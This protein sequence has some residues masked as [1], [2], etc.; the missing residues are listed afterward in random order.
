MRM[1][2]LKIALTGLASVALGSAAVASDVFNAGAD[3]LYAGA[4]VLNGH[5]CDQHYYGRHYNDPY[6]VRYYNDPYYDDRN[7]PTAAVKAGP[8]IKP[9]KVQIICRTQRLPWRHGS[10]SVHVCYGSA[11]V[12]SSGW[13]PKPQKPPM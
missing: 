8:D 6:Y 1:P 10:Y 3:V 11:P 9:Q 13:K 12:L 4:D 2:V 5:Y 7:Y